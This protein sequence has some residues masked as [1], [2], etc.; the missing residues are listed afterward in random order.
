MNNFSYNDL[1]RI[2]V[3]SLGNIEEIKV[4][5]NQEIA[6]LKRVVLGADDY[7]SI[8]VSLCFHLQHLF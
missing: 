8:K 6:R 7:Q 1:F 3:R 4:D 5:A 2:K